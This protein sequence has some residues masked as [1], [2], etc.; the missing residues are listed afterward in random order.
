MSV[1]YHSY[2]YKWLSISQQG[3]GLEHRAACSLIVEYYEVLCLILES[4]SF[5]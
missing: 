4:I 1:D 5:S 2:S 3:C